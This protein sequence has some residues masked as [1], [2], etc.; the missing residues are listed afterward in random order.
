[1]MPS[2]KRWPKIFSF[3]SWLLCLP[4]LQKSFD[5]LQ[6][7]ADPGSCS[8][9]AYVMIFSTVA[10]NAVNRV[11]GG[12]RLFLASLQQTCNEYLYLNI[13]KSK[14]AFLLQKS[15]G[16]FWVIWL[17]FSIF[18]I[19]SMFSMLPMFSKLTPCSPIRDCRMEQFLQPLS[20]W[21]LRLHVSILLSQ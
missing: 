13:N 15:S 14:L 12:K 1:M 4:G 16:D 6:F 8:P 10:I 7:W 5:V 18:S 17:M 9:S 3:L 20:V 21:C 19:F 2:G 11:S